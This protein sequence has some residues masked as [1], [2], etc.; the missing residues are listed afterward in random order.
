MTIIDLFEGFKRDTLN[1]LSTAYLNVCKYFLI[2]QR[3]IQNSMG[4]IK[5]SKPFKS[6][7]NTDRYS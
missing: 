6:L 5:C 4:N 7:K 2:I 3:N 1:D